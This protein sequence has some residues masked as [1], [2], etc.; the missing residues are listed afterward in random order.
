MQLS[1]QSYLFTKLISIIILG[2][3]IPLGF[4][5]A[6]LMLIPRKT[7]PEKII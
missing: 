3:I 6:T 7:C 4:Y 5:L 1:T 2:G